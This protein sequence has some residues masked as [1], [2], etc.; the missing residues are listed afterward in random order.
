MNSLLNYGSFSRSHAPAWECI[1]LPL[2]RG[3]GEYFGIRSRARSD[4]GMKTW[5]MPEAP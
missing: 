5:A 2:P 4:D 1:R 3:T